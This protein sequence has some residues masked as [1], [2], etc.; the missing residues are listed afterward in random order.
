MRLDK[1]DI[2]AYLEVVVYDNCKEDFALHKITNACFQGMVDAIVTVCKALGT[3]S[4]WKE[5]TGNKKKFISGRFTWNNFRSFL[6]T[7]FMNYQFRVCD[8]ETEEFN[9]YNGGY[10]HVLLEVLAV[11][12]IEELYKERVYTPLHP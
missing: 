8:K 12:C 5:V 11:V 1:D 3:D 9:R 7:K 2:R 10:A 4:E 6:V